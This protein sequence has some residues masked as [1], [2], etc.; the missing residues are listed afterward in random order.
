MELLHTILRLALGRLPPLCP[1]S[2]T[3]RPMH[4]GLAIRSIPTIRFRILAQHRTRHILRNM[5]GS[6]LR[7]SKRSI[8]HMSP[9]RLPRLPVQL[10][11]PLNVRDALSYLDQVKFQFA[12][13]PEVYNRFLDIMKDFKSQEIDTPGV[14]ERV[15]TLFRSQPQLIIGFNTF[16]P[17]GYS[18]EPTN[19]PNDPVRVTTP[20]NVQYQPTGLG[21]SATYPKMAASTAPPEVHHPP[22]P[23]HPVV[24]PQAHYPPAQAP[25]PPPET[26]RVPAAAPAEPPRPRGPVEFNHA[27]NY[28]NK[29]KTR[30]ANQPETYRYF[31]EILQTYQKEDKPIKEVYAQVQYLFAGAP[32]LLEEFKQFLPDTSAGAH[33]VPNAPTVKKPAKRNV[34][35]PPPSH[36]Y[37]Q[38]AVQAPPKKKIK[39]GRTDKPSTAEEL[40]F[41]D[42]CKRVIGNKTTYNEFLKILNLFTQEQIEAKILIERV[43]PFLGK[44]PELFEWFKRF[45]KYDDDEIIYVLNDDWVGL[46]VFLS[47]NG[48]TAHKKTPNEEAMFK[49]EE[50]RYE[51]DL[52]IEANLSVINLLEPIAKKIQ[53]MPAEERANFKIL[54][55]LGG[56]ST[57]IYK[58]VIKKIYDN[59]KGL[60]VIEA[61]HH[62]PAVAVPIVL[63]RLKQKDEEWKRSQREWNKV[64]REIDYKNF[65]KALDHQGI[66]FKISD[67]KAVVQKYLVNEIEVLQLEQREKKSNL[68]NRYQYDFSFKKRDI[69][70]HVHQLLVN[71]VETSATIP[72]SE[73]EKIRS[74]L[75][76]FVPKMFL[77]QD[78]LGAAPADETAAM[79]VDA[80]A[81]SEQV[82]TEV[83][84]PS[85]ME[86]DAPTAEEKN[87]KTPLK[88]R[89]SHTLYAN[90][91]I[92]AFFRLYQMLFSRLA[93]MKE[94]SDELA[95]TRPRGDVKNQVAL[96]LGLRKDT[97]ATMTEKD[98]FTELLKDITAFV[99]GDM[100]SNDFEDK[101]RELFWTSGYLI[102]T[103]DKLVQALVKQLQL[104]ALDS[105]CLE[106]LSIYD[107]DRE[108]NTTGPRQEALYRLCAE[109]IIQDENIYRIEYFFSEC[110]LTIQLLGKEDQVSDEAISSEEKWSLYVDQFV[111]LSTPENASLQHRKPF[112]KRNLPTQVGED[113]PLNVETKSGLELK[114]CV[115]TY[116][117][118]FVDNTEDYFRRKRS[119]NNSSLLGLTET[120]KTRSYTEM[121]ERKSRKLHSWLS[122]DRGWKQ[123]LSPQEI[124]SNQAAIEALKNGN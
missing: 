23:T 123:G 33:A 102:F 73:E 119:T 15:S 71:F 57:T 65:A 69:F 96:E 113:P 124:A 38:P 37:Q 36:Y 97:G 3:C 21:A 89:S 82:A 55:G 10:P 19:N 107:R 58:R 45:V 115:N 84:D 99:N 28:V 64:W 4:Q 16:L 76:E 29:I 74:L 87:D 68:A 72:T 103:V 39:V 60:E 104:I 106:L 121:Q 52:N 25:I 79:E 31:L 67:R 50:E 100:E 51:F 17:P 44:S 1:L 27:I 11:R 114:I 62:N 88:K 66:N 26:R 91:M 41:F 98:R 77:I 81:E 108:K 6:L 90:N 8:P 56:F 40:E 105:K 18:L 5:Q 101:T 9:P 42:K 22:H 48:F 61:L 85:A 92:Y 35:A 49:C 20:A 63:K 75:N 59:D 109:Q 47:E 12:G 122:S 2:T 30:F 14:I 120:E 32:D 80:P 46:P 117:I 78:S 95:D 43:E 34:P 93:R 86:V 111:Q 54:P 94:V 83:A 118:F 112:L 70:K 110:V 116:K 24:P 53:L 7:P 13:Q